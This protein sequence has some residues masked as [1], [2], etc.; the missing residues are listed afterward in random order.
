METD[1][2][3]AENASGTLIE[4]HSLHER[5]NRLDASLNFEINRKELYLKNESKGAF[6][7]LD[8]K[9]NTIWNDNRLQL[10]SSP[11]RR[12]FSD[13]LDIKLPLSND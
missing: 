3:L 6:D 10:S 1:Y 7:W 5:R 13:I 8:S 2:L 4:S 11:D 12:Y 9:S